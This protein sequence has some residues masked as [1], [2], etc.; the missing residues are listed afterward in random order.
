MDRTNRQIERV[1]E[2]KATGFRT[3]CGFSEGLRGEREILH[4]LWQAGIR[5][6]SSRLMGENGTLPA[7]L[8]EPFWYD[9]EDILRPL[10]ELPTQGW[11]D[12]ILKGYNPCPVAWPPPFPWGY[13]AALPR[14]PEEAFSVYRQELDLACEKPMTYYAPIFH[15]WAVNRF[16]SNAGEVRLLLEYVKNQ[17]IPTYNY[18][19][20]YTRMAEERPI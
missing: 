8:T 20:M 9:R 10:M 2:R 5:Y 12:N 17:G 7:P 16:S 6:V 18:S 3:P 13:P 11:H 1:T 15:P 19:Q 14:T 4:V